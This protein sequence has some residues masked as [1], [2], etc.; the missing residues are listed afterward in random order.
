MTVVA[1]SGLR[2]LV[3]LSLSVFGC[4]NASHSQDS[5]IEA[6]GEPEHYSATVVRIADDQTT[7]GRES[8]DGEKRRQEWTENGH[9]RALIWSTDVGKAFLLDLDRRTYIEIALNDKRSPQPGS[10]TPPIPVEP[11]GID[12]TIQA[13]DQYFAEKAPPTRVETQ[14][15]APAVIDGRT[16]IVHQQ[17]AS[18]PDGHTETTR[19]FYSR[20]LSGLVLR[21]ES[22]TDNGRIR[23]ITERRD[24]RLEVAPDAFEIPAGFKKVETLEP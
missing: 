13:I 9:N 16:C 12:N 17:I 18:F 23:V 14:T 2:I 24:I 8:R 20:E 5:E 1:K 15:L 3:I 6:T 4:R 7:V 10:V 11:G 21:L 19:R 22:E